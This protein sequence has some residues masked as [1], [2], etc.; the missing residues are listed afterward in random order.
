[1]KTLTT[2]KT[3]AVSLNKGT[4]SKLIDGQASVRSAMNLAIHQE[5]TL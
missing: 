2:H 4:S 3:M 1:M 5:L